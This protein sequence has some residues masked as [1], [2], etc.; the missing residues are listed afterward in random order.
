MCS[1]SA[2]TKST[3]KRRYLE[4]A[5][6]FI[7]TWY[8]YFFRFVLTRQANFVYVC[9][10]IH[11]LCTTRSTALL[12]AHIHL[13][14]VQERPIGFGI[15]NNLGSLFD[16]LFVSA[17]L[18]YLRNSIVNSASRSLACLFFFFLSNRLIN[19]SYTACSWRSLR[20]KFSMELEKYLFNMFYLHTFGISLRF[21][22]EHRET[23]PF[24]SSSIVPFFFFS[25]FWYND[26]PLIR[27]SI[28]PSH[29]GNSVFLRYQQAC[30]T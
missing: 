30:V 12:P 15:K 21:P 3:V 18:Y 20:S 19:L 5:Q 17:S 7:K 29:Y 25:S 9:I 27:S 26:R 22:V 24:A 8:L 23:G 11:L 6:F 1:V 14:F 16:F 10:S 28:L 4:V 2:V 13:T